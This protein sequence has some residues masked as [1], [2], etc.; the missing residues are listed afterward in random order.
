MSQIHNYE[1]GCVEEMY[2]SWFKEQ[3]RPRYWQVIVIV[4]GGQM[5]SLC[6]KELCQVSSMYNSIACPN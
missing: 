3:S 5:M 1:T 6:I 2:H 4:F